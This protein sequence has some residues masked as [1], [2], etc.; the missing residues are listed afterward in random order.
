MHDEAILINGTGN[1]APNGSTVTIDK[2]EKI[3]KSTAAAKAETFI[4][5]DMN[6]KVAVI[7]VITQPT[8]PGRKTSPSSYFRAA[9]VKHAAGCT[10]MAVPS[11]TN[12]TPSIGTKAAHPTKAAI[13]TLWN[14]NR[15]PASGSALPTS[16][17]LKALGPTVP[18]SSNKISSSGTGSSKR[19]TNNVKV[20]AMAWKSMSPSTRATTPFLANWNPGGTFTTGIWDLS[21][22]T[23]TQPVSSPNRI[24]RGTISKI[25][26]G[27]SGYVLVLTEKHSLGRE[28]WVWVKTAVQHSGPSGTSLWNRLTTG[29]V[30]LGSE[31]YA[32]GQFAH[33]TKNTKNWY[34]LSVD[35]WH[36]ICIF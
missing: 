13:T 3:Y 26:F 7:A 22:T 24:Y 21:H 10:R 31:I 32:L 2:V 5:A 34:S 4:C 27:K 15:G 12:P 20:V 19:S 35:D 6:C 11:L 36:D 23:I 9:S 8:K 16:T 33:N 30:P 28:L 25:H 14:S 17:S 1:I 29:S 18:L